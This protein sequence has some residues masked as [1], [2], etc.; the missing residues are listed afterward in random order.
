MFSERLSKPKKHGFAFQ[1]NTWS[2]NGEESIWQKVEG[3]SMSLYAAYYDHRAPQHYIRILGIFRGRNP[4]SMDQLFCQMRSLSGEDIVEVVAAKPLEIWWHEWD[5]TSLEV[6]TPLLLSCPLMEPLKETSIVSIITEPCNDP[7]NAFIVKRKH[8]VKYERSFTIC[9]KDM[10]FQNNIS[11]S[12]LEWIETNRL[13]GAEAIDMYLD[14][15]HKNTEAILQFYQSIG[16]VRLFKVPIKSNPERSLWQRRR[17][18]IISYN[19]CLYRNLIESS[20]L[21]PLDID[22]VI[23]PKIAYT[24]SHLVNRLSRQ[25]WDSY[26]HSAILIR[27]VFFFKSMQDRNKHKYK[28]ANRKRKKI[29]DK[30][31]DVRIID[32]DFENNDI[33]ITEKSDNN[34]EE[35]DNEDFKR[36]I[37]ACGKEIAMPKLAHHTVR[38]ATISPIGHYS[39]SFMLTNRVLTAFNH[40]PLASVGSMGFTAWAAPLKEVQL[41]H[42][43]ESCN[44]T[45]VSECGQYTQRGRLDESALRLNRRLTRALKNALCLQN[46]NTSLYTCVFFSYYKDMS[47]T[48][49]IFYTVVQHCVT[50]SGRLLCTGCRLDY[51]YHNGAYFSREAV[52]CKRYCV[53]V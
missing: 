10:N 46:K 14:S 20:F 53:S 8:T 25:G 39:K 15:V 44:V 28:S 24:W 45:V 40:Y 21:I 37:V 22:E 7:V 43:K 41:N 4:T 49:T 3:Q 1:N 17:D 23:I 18:H 12:L 34:I 48:I 6:E 5:N 11:D 52:M 32:N 47:P 16:F 13:L 19:D 26:H 30:R 9:V 31:D 29:Y 42:Y 50:T 51:G 38:S 33:D 35:N 36:G 27:N 2:P